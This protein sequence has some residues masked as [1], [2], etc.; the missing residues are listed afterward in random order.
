MSADSPPP[1]SPLSRQTRPSVDGPLTDPSDGEWLTAKGRA[2]RQVGEQQTGERRWRARW[3][4]AAV[5][6]AR[7]QERWGHSAVVW[8]G[9]LVVFGGCF[10]AQHFSTVLALDLAALAWS[11]LSAHGCLPPPSDCHSATLLSHSRMLVFGGTDGTRRLHCAHLLHLPSRRWTRVGGGAGGGDVRAGWVEGGSVIEVGGV[12]EEGGVDGSGMEGSERGTQGGGGAMESGASSME[13][14]V[15]GRGGRRA[16]VARRGS[17]ESHVSSS[18]GARHGGV[19]GGGDGIMWLMTQDSCDYNDGSSMAVGRSGGLERNAIPEDDQIAAV[20][21]PARESHVAAVVWLPRRRGQLEG[22]GGSMVEWRETVGAGRG[23]Y[24]NDLWGLDVRSMA[25]CR[26]HGAHETPLHGHAPCGVHH[27]MSRGTARHPPPCARD[28]HSMVAMGGAG[29]QQALV[30]FGGDCG[31]RYLNDLHVLHVASLSWRPISP[32]AGAE[33]PAPRAGHCAVAVTPSQMLLLGGVGDTGCFTDTWLFDLPSATWHQLLPPITASPAGLARAAEG[34]QVGASG[35][36]EEEEAQQQPR[37]CFSHTASLLPDGTVAVFGGCGRDEQPCS[38]LM[39]LRLHFSAASPPPLSPRAPS[40]PWLPAPAT[41]SSP[42]AA[43]AASCG[44]GEERS[45][46][47]EIAEILNQG[48]GLWRRQGLRPRG[49]AAERGCEREGLWARATHC[50]VQGCCFVESQAL[51]PCIEGRCQYS[52][53]AVR[54]AWVMALPLVSHVALKGHASVCACSLCALSFSFPIFR[55]FPS[56]PLGLPSLLPRSSGAP[57]TALPSTVLCSSLPQLH[58]ACVVGE[59]AAPAG[60]GGQQGR[61]RGRPRRYV[62]SEAGERMVRQALRARETGGGGEVGGGSAGVAVRETGSALAAREV[63][64]GGD[65]SL[66]RGG[67][68]RGG[69]G[70]DGGDVSGWG[71]AV[72]GGAATAGNSA[73]RGAGRR[74]KLQAKRAGSGGKGRVG[75]VRGRSGAGGSGG[76][77]GSGEVGEASGMGEGCGAWLCR[78]ELEAADETQHAACPPAAAATDRETLVAAQQQSG[79]AWAHKGSKSAA[80]TASAAALASGSML[81]AGG[82]F[83][84]GTLPVSLHMP[85]PLCATPAAPLQLHSPNGHPP[86]HHLAVPLPHSTRPIVALHGRPVG[87]QTAHGTAGCGGGAGQRGGEVGVRGDGRGEGGVWQ[88]GEEGEQGAVAM[89]GEVGAG[90]AALHGGQRWPSHAR[91]LHL[92]IGHVVCCPSGAS[93]S[94]R[95]DGHFDGGVTLAARVNGHTLTGVLLAPPALRSLLLSPPPPRPS[96]AP[97][98]L[99][100]ALPPSRP[101]SPPATTPATNG[102]LTPAATPAADSAAVN[103][104]GCGS[105]TVPSTGGGSAAAVVLLAPA[106]VAAA[107][108]CSVSTHSGPTP[109]A[110][111]AD[112]HTQKPGG[113]GRGGGGKKRQRG[114]AGRGKRGKQS[115]GGAGADEA[116]EAREG[117]VARRSKA[118]ARKGQMRG[119]GSWGGGGMEERGRGEEKVVQVV[120]AGGWVE[121]MAA[122]GTQERQ[123]VAVTKHEGGARREGGGRGEWVREEQHR[124]YER[125]GR[126]EALV[127]QMQEQ[128]QQQQQH[129]LQQHV[130][131]DERAGLHP[132]AALH[133]SR[134]AV[135]TP[136]HL[137]S[138]PSHAP[139]TALLPPQHCE[140]TMA[141]CGSG[142]ELTHGEGGE[143]WRAVGGVSALPEDMEARAGGRG[144]GGRGREEGMQEREHDGGLAKWYG[145]MHASVQGD[146]RLQLHADTDGGE[147]RG[148][149]HGNGMEA[150]KGGAGLDAPAAM[151]TAHEAEAAHGA[152]SSRALH[153][154]HGPLDNHGAHICHGAPHPRGAHG[155][156][157]MEQWM[158]ELHADVDAAHQ[159]A[160]HATAGGGAAGMVHGMAAQP[161]AH[162]DMSPGLHQWGSSTGGSGSG[163]GSGDWQLI[164]SPPSPLH[165]MGFGSSLHSPLLHPLSQPLTHTSPSSPPSLHLSPLSLPP[166]LLPPLHL[167]PFPTS[168]HVGSSPT[169]HAPQASRLSHSQGSA[170]KDRT[171]AGAGKHGRQGEAGRGPVGGGGTRN[172]EG[173]GMHD[174][175]G[176]HKDGESGSNGGDSPHLE[177]IRFSP[178]HC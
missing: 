165:L 112:T 63:A 36:A 106:A 134:A 108:A 4:E 124:E 77:G 6:G 54:I 156:S 110:A 116:E 20:H 46:V 177:L 132:N 8:D 5:A 64:A 97:P 150:G 43:A 39:L 42:P 19:G 133:P 114:G 25:W 69:G 62:V 1:I 70:D 58:P 85:A 130:L 92:G 83:K 78:S 135:H 40:S 118:R 3:Q 101:S 172:G 61:P 173:V 87:G 146:V 161:H 35:A 52:R 129:L 74:A 144:V 11:P 121:Q 123:G 153:G 55:S 119:E 169:P 111:S 160:L 148:G 151:A 174:G 159:H 157:S 49:V 29:E 72:R 176:G 167:P 12:M 94:V 56:A 117:E 37:A 33:W 140:S 107:A 145:G 32:A 171:G 131:G 59:D 99:S 67:E 45:F 41:T 7:P 91:L 15:A 137:P 31:A 113:G 81:H 84:D 98:S 51:Y 138:M 168:D 53:C 105:L 71:A 2:G 178:L 136:L 57:S 170:P 16:Q 164:A 152:D 128:Q 100:P 80:D 14:A 50:A 149:Q 9:K 142:H 115:A 23:R 155:M 82:S 75:E 147:S 102:R 89:A 79:M 76:I 65:G 109:S 139:R 17:G 96:H 93:L 125:K 30:V 60:G 86:E 122:Q 21:P 27:H 143:Q 88:G 154:P 28:S 103:T 163:S 68:E 141:R 158:A 13:T 48:Q 120:M 90:A 66:G 10:G 104:R 73:S 95:V 126:R 127:P 162:G 38:D 22:G 24:L 47:D 175:G 44:E 18:R 166:L 34:E 26:L